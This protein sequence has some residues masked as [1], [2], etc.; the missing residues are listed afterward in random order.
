M[1]PAK[2]TGKGIDSDIL[3]R[4]FT[5]F[6]TTSEKGTG[7]GLYICKGIIEAHNG[8]IWADNNYDRSRTD[9]TNG[10]VDGAT[11]SFSLPLSHY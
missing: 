11:I 10:E 5:I 1:I 7:F 8:R 6:T 2:D 3:P 9:A 4:L